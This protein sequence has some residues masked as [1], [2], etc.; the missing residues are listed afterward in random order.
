MRC[1]RWTISI[2]LAAALIVANA[3]ASAHDESKYPD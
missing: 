2:A 3:A 1:N